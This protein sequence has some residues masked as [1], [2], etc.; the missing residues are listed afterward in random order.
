MSGRVSLYGREVD[1]QDAV[2]EL[3]NR[4]REMSAENEKYRAGAANTDGGDAVE[5]RKN[6]TFLFSVGNFD[7]KPDEDVDAFFEKLENAAHLGS[8]SDADILRVAKLQ[9]TG[10]A[11]EYARSKEEVREAETYRQFKEELL[12]RYR[13]KKSTRF[14]REVLTTIKKS[15]GEDIEA[16]A[17]RIRKINARTYAT[18]G[19]PEYVASQRYEADQRALDTFLA[20]LPGELGRQCRL[21]TPETFD[22]A[23]Q[24]AVRVR[25]VERRP[26][27]PPPV[28]N[29]YRAPAER[30]CFNCGEAS[31]LAR[32]C[33]RRRR[34]FSCGGEDHLARDCMQGKHHGP[35]R[36]L[37]GA[38]AGGAA[39]TD[40]W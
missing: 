16:F 12:A 23:V 17:D 4:L 19:A 29:I 9:L 27:V 24:V 20:G 2:D 36:D 31:H 8:W 14:Y 11:A 18:G 33:S 28:R 39:D 7:G 25:E 5:R 10:G 30:R 1:L 40:P 32:Q 34:C 38:G 21:A 6:F 37:N 35:R 13:S 3:S 26:E 15:Q 22:A